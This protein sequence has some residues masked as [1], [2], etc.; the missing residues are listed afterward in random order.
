MNDIDELNIGIGVK[1]REIRKSQKLNQAILAQ[2]ANIRQASLSDIENGK[3]EIKISEMIEI[4]SLLK[5]P[6]IKLLPAS[7]TMD[8][9]I[10]N[11]SDD[12]KK[13]VNLYRNMSEDDQV[14]LLG[15]A[16]SF[17]NHNNT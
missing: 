4:C 7:I 12:E 10:G 15:I 8:W 16:K 17:L 14:R 11:I 2:N 3:R 1:I 6:L 13:L 5:V 9:L